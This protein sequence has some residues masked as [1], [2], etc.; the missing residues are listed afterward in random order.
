MNFVCKYTMSSSSEPPG[1][2]PSEL[3][4]LVTAAAM[5]RGWLL[6]D[7]APN[8]EANTTA[9][10][11][12]F[13]DFLGNSWGFLSSHPQDFTPVCSTELSR[14]AKLAS[15]FAKRNVKLIALSIDSVEDHLAWSKDINAY[16]GEEPTEKL[17]FPIFDDKNRD[18]T[19]VLGMLDP[20]EKD[21]KDMPAAARVVFVIGPDKKLKLSI[22][23]PATIGGNFDE[24]LP[25][26]TSP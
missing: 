21:E 22:I 3:H 17:P 13:H 11:V 15:E 26:V 19:I 4:L 16:N 6:G 9:S 8:F 7:V 18:L 10:R 12:R 5:P 25:I 24:I 14:A 2:L 20:A 23:Y 1:W